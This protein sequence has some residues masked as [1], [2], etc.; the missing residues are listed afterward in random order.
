VSR[1]GRLPR[2]ADVALL[3]PH[4]GKVAG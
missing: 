2:R 1:R 3:A 4:H